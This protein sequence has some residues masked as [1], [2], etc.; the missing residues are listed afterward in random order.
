MGGELFMLFLL[1][2]TT[3]RADRGPKMRRLFLPFAVLVSL[4]ALAPSAGASTLFV[5]RGHGWGHGIGL[6]Q[7]GAYGYAQHGW[8]YPR[9]L[10]HYYQGTTLGS[11][12]VAR[13]RVLLADGRTALLIGSA[14]SFRVRDANGN[15]YTL[16]AGTHRLGPRMRVVTASGARRTLAS[17]ARFYHGPSGTPVELGG[18]AYRGNLYVRSRNGLLSVRNDVGLEQYLY[19]VVPWE[20]P[21]SWSFAA[22]RAQA[23]VART[24]GLVSR[25]SGAWFDLYADTRSQVYGGIR[26]ENRRTTKAVNDTAGKVV[27]HDGALAWTFYHSTSG[28]RTAAIQDVWTGALPKSYLVGVV[29]RYDGI[30]HHHDWGPRDAETD[31][32]GTRRDCVWGARTMKTR[33]GSRAPSGLRDLTVTL[34]GSDRVATVRAVGSSGTTTIAAG[35]FQAVLGLRST[36]FSIGVLRVSPSPA[37]IE[38]G[39]G[40]RLSVLARGMPRSVLQRKRYGGSWENVR[41]VTG[42]VRLEVA[43]RIRTSYRVASRYA[44]GALARIAVAPKLRFRQEQTRS[45]LAGIMRPKRAGTTV[46]VQRLT[47]DGWKKV[48]EA[49]VDADGNWRATLRVRAGTYRA[50]AAPG[51]GLIAGTSPTLEIVTG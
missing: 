28:G 11:A 16:A 2:W 42:R 10:A 9:I 46:A 12:G 3:L 29:D 17:P 33:L 26:A 25:K 5:L 23:V 39:Q 19:G 35:T 40:S 51:N 7:W 1:L 18:S 6:A 48:A 38:W 13:V 47:A 14:A 37:R 41:A 4:L 15:R 27:R 31:C 21:A 44:T 24:Y 43:P 20:M 50:Y 30:S 22:L 45:S 8:T 36:W 34:N 32:V 49:T